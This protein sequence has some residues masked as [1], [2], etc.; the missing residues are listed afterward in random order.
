[1]NKEDYHVI[2]IIGE[3]SMTGGMAYEALN[4]AL[5]SG[6]RLII[7]LNDNGMSIS[8]TMGAFAKLLGHVR[9]DHKYYKGTMASKKILNSNAVGRF[10][11]RGMRQIKRAFK[12]LF[13]PT[14]LWESLG[15]AY[16]GPIDGHNI[17][18]LES[19]FIAAKNYER[20]SVLLHVV[21]KKGKGYEPAETNPSFYHGVPPARS[22][23][24]TVKSYSQV[25]AETMQKMMEKDD[26]IV[27]ITPAMPEGN[28]LLD[29]QK[30]FPDRI[31]DV[32]ICEQ[33][34]VTFAAGLASSGIKP[35][36]AIYST[37][38]QRAFD[39]IIHDVALQNLPVTF[40]ID[41][42]GI[43]GD[44]GKTHQGIFDL[45]YLSL[46]P[47]LN[48]AAP[49]DENMLQ[50]LLYTSVYHSKHPMA[51][52]YPRGSG[53]GVQIDD[54]FKQIKIGTAEKLRDGKD[55]TILPIGYCVNEAVKAADILKSQHNIDAEIID[56]IFAKPADIT[57]IM[58]SVHKTHKLL[59][60]EENVI[61]SGFGSNIVD[62]LHNHDLDF[63]SHSVGIRDEFVEHGPQNILRKQYG[64]DC[65]GIVEN[66]LTFLHKTK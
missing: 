40:A 48:I 27:V 52:R 41:R 34:A 6:S 66:T 30:E 10:I 14:T 32:G 64:I 5:S 62:I 36:V 8:P 11:W 9:F 13:L 31:I 16:Y 38:L 22:K 4:N 39:Q 54:N 12:G 55:I 3:G 50:N 51:I 23:S 57:L 33:H 59:T 53:I 49:R 24:K 18:D 65:D 7:I 28:C 29:L 44:D 43:V 37:F 15:L 60:V 42:G 61:L 19:A 26:K 58:D 45:S 20:K 63:E 56:P 21:T 17:K 2:A 25:F 46:I 47:N 35:V 1:M